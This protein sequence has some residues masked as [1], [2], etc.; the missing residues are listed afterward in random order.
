MSAKKIVYV[1]LDVDDTAFHGAGI[2]RET[3]EL[4]EF[5]CKPDHGVLCKKLNV[6]FKDQYTIRL[7]YEACYIGYSLCRFLR[8]HGIHCD[9]IAPSLIPVKTGTRVKKHI[10]LMLPNLQNIMPRIY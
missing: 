9:V 2:V 7:C 4:F 3:D 10:G 8:K 6:L 1:G 5:K